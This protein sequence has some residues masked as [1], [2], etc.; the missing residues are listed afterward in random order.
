MKPILDITVCCTILDKVL[1]SLLLSTE[2]E[3]RLQW[4]LQSH[5]I[6]LSNKFV[7]LCEDYFKKKNSG[8]ELDLFQSFIANIA[9]SQQ[10]VKMVPDFNGDLDPK[11]KYNNE[12]LGICSESE[13]KILLSNKE[14]LKNTISRQKLDISF[15]TESDS[16]NAQFSNI[17]FRYTLPITH[18]MLPDTLSNQT[19]ADWLGRFLKD[20]TSI[21]IYDNFLLTPNEINAF[22]KYILPFIQKGVYS[23]GIS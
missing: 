19:V 1:A 9:G 11:N 5:R 21:Q 7:S 4:I 8:S 15:Y 17:L 13:D 22:N 23:A 10:S 3:R 20:E 18:L 14:K 12:L 2:D 16:L 6:I